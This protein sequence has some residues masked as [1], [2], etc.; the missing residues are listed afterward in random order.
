MDSER[1]EPVDRRTFVDRP[2]AE[3]AV[4]GH[5]LAEQ[6]LVHEP[7]LSH[8]GLPSSRGQTRQHLQPPISPAP[9]DPGEA[10]PDRDARPGPRVEGANPVE[11]PG[12]LA[13]DERPV[14]HSGAT[15]RV[16]HGGLATQALEVDVELDVAESAAGEM[17]EGLIQREVAILPGI[18]DGVRKDQLAAPRTNV[19]LNHVHADLQRRVK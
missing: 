10:S 1:T 12:H 5:D 11:N 2:C 9:A 4:A 19:E 13:G 6:R 17:I 8:H 14:E 7:V 18:E 15:Q 3:P 16:E